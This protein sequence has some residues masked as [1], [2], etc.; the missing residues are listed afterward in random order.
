MQ[1]RI[2]FPPHNNTET[3][4]QAAKNAKPRKGQM[5]ILNQM[6]EA[7]NGLTRDELAVQT[8]LP[9]ATVCARVNE[10]LKLGELMGRNTKEGKPIRRQTRAGQSAQVLFL[11]SAS[12]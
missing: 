11:T 5:M 7:E 1:R 9:T 3:S 8:G 10:L 6:I 12:T 4:K 2:V